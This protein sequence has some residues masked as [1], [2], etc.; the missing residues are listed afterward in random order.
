MDGD[1]DSMLS[2]SLDLLSQTKRDMKLEDIDKFLHDQGIDVSSPIA[3]SGRSHGSSDNDALSIER[4]LREQGIT[5]PARPAAYAPGSVGM[6]SDIVDDSQREGD[7]SGLEHQLAQIG[8][9]VESTA[10][11][12]ESPSL[13]ESGT[14][15]VFRAGQAVEADPT[16]SGIFADAVVTAVHHDLGDGVQYD[17]VSTDGRLHSN[18]EARYI[19]PGSSQGSSLES[20]PQSDS[21]HKLDADPTL[22]FDR[23]NSGAGASNLPGSADALAAYIQQDELS[24]AADAAIRATKP[25]EEVAASG[26][27]GYAEQEGDDEAEDE[28]DEEDEEDG[29]DA[30]D[31]ILASVGLTTGG[32]ADHD[33]Y[34][35]MR[36]LPSARRLPETSP[37]ASAVSVAVDRSRGMPSAMSASAGG[38]SSGFSP[39]VSTWGPLNQKLE[40]YSIAPLPLRRIRDSHARVRVRA[41][42]E[43]E[44]EEVGGLLP[45]A[46]YAPDPTALLERFGTLLATCEQHERRLGELMSDEHTQATRRRRQQQLQ[47]DGENASQRSGESMQRALRAASGKCAELEEEAAAATERA[48]D[49]VRRLRVANKNLQQQLAQS[50]HKAKAKEGLCERLKARLDSEVTKEKSESERDKELFKKLAQRDSRPGS[51]ADAQSIEVREPCLHYNPPYILRPSTPSHIHLPPSPPTSTYPHSRIQLT[52]LP[53]IIASDD[54]RLRE[55]AGRNGSRATVPAAAGEAAGGPVEAAGE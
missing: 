42:D 45:P 44:D 48:K 53:S 35:H 30:A 32:D 28:E 29:L 52:W 51:V 26:S 4:L 36:E 10:I 8:R 40:E 39:T 24:A 50:E 41:H 21:Q 18:I 34:H 11:L 25:A 3:S 33:S 55:A 37:S 46:L 23:S 31:R 7:I 9:L 54:P 22:D 38:K 17:L 19:R 20:S 12:S 16:A 13:S 47:E 15:L 5:P 27:Q 1:G 14:K 49:H 6:S 43:D 2:G